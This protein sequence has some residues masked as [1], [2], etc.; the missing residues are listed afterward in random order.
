MD[1]DIQFGDLEEA[2][3]ETH[4]RPD[5]NKHYAVVAYDSPDERDLPIFIDLDVMRDIEIHAQSNTNVELGGVL[6]GGQYE[7][8]DGEPFVIITDS[9][10]AQHYEATKGSFKF[11]HETW[12]QISRERDSF[13]DDLQMVGWYHTHPDWGV[14]L[15]GMDMFI[16]DNFFNK[17]LD[18]A[19]V[20]DPCR[21]D[22][23]MFMWT[24]ESSARIRQTGGFFLVSSR[25]RQRELEL[26]ATQL[27]GKFMMAGD[28]RYSGAAQFGPMPAPVVNISEQRNNP[29]QG[30]AIMGML[31]MQFLVLVLIAWK[32]L[33]P[34][35][36]ADEK[37]TEQ[38]AALEK[39][40][41]DVSAGQDRRS[42]LDV[43]GEILDALVARL[44]GGEKGV[45][46]EL[47]D[48]KRKY[49]RELLAAEEK[50]DVYENLR[51][52]KAALASDLTDARATSAARKKSLDDKLEEL[53]AAN[54]K[55]K[56]H[57]REIA[58]LKK[59]L[60]GAEDGGADKESSSSISWWTIGIASGIVLVLLVAGVAA[61]IALRKEDEEKA[62]KKPADEKSE[63]KPNSDKA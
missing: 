3:P 49:E 50:L 42:R 51:K 60:K 38:I 22:R 24:G 16:C 9:L 41:D 34:P 44:E 17:P 39:K 25:F 27:E 48:L 47:E 54:S 35:A 63:E 5:R 61:A 40:V 15:S 31:T 12:E 23:G 57:E 30:I 32:L 28:P 7:D 18:V 13:P 33:A 37:L 43:Q 11:T 8:E 2:Q 10:R 46:L 20:V 21:R 45:V 59:E 62:K 56:E 53:A 36:A 55:I 26:F 19:L 58:T 52:T 1:A 29:W 14:F 6:L 4:L